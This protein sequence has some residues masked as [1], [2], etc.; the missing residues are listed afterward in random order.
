MVDEQ[1]RKTFLLEP[2]RNGRISRRCTG[3]ELIDQNLKKFFRSNLNSATY[4][5]VACVA[6]IP[7]ISEYKKIVGSRTLD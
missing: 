3:V 1:I 7:H 4:F 6:I 2:I 5:K